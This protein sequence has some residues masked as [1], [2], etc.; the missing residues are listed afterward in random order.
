MVRGETIN[1]M[2]KLNKLAAQCLKTFLRKG[3]INQSSSSKVLVAIISADWRRLW[4]ATKHKSESNPHYS[5]R[6]DAAAD[7]I[8]SA[9]TYLQYI[10]CDSIEDLLRQKIEDLSSDK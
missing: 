6:E 8:I 9:V 3:V 5:E 1:Y 7:V 4:G 2:I 10:G